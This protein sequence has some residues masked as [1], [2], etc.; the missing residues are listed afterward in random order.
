MPITDE[1]LKDF[2][3]ANDYTTYA[4]K[5]DASKATTAENRIHS[6][7]KEL[8]YKAWCSQLRGMGGKASLKNFS[9]DY[10]VKLLEQTTSR[11]S[12]RRTVSS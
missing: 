12:S 7:A 4:P 11:A 10:P 5:Y 8:F 3:R 2:F 9:K 6:R 1:E